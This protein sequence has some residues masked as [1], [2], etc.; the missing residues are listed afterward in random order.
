MAR[1]HL[2]GCFAQPVLQCT[3]HTTKHIGPRA[4]RLH[5][6]PQAAYIFIAPLTGGGTMTVTCCTQLNMILRI[7]GGVIARLYT[8]WLRD[9]LHQKDAS[10]VN[11]AK[12]WRK[13]QAGFDSWPFCFSRRAILP[14]QHSDWPRL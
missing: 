2:T 3:E 6:G 13:I 12:A 7:S 1:Q 14:I 9:W 11:E 4:E 10:K 5:P 8:P